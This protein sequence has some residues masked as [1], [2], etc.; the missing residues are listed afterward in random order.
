MPNSSENYNLKL[1]LQNEYY[2]VD[3]FNSNFRII[4]TELKKLEENKEPKIN[5]KSGFNLDKT[6]VPENNTNKL[7]SAKGA[8]DLK[9]WLVSA[10][11]NAINTTK[12]AL[13][14]LIK[15]KLPHG[16]YGGT[17]QDLKNLVD[18]KEPKIKRSSSVTSTSE[19]DVATSKAVKSA[20]DNANIRL[21]NGY[22]STDFGGNANNI[23][24]AQ[25]L[26]LIKSKGAFQQSYW[27]GRGS[28]YYAGN[29]K[30]NDTGCGDIHLAGAVVEVFGT[31]GSHTIRITTPTTSVGGIVNAEFIYVNNGGDYSPGWRKNY[32]N[33][34]KP[35]PSEIGTYTKQEID[36]RLNGKLNNNYC[37]YAVGQ[38]LQTKNIANPATLYPGTTWKK[39]EGRFL[40]ATSG[41]EAA[42]GTGG[43]SSIKILEA[44]LPPHGHKFSA[45]T[46][47]TG[48]H[49]HQNEKHRHKVDNHSHTQP[50]HT[51]AVSLASQGGVFQKLS[52]EKTYLKGPSH[53]ENAGTVNFGNVTAAGGETTGGSAPYTDYQNPNTST[54][55]NHNHTV[56]GTTSTT[57]SGA[58]INIM[59]LYHKVHIWERT[60]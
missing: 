58:A 59:P 8:L 53:R 54:D 52:S 11:T 33:K 17:G 51:H 41:S 28:W 13:E 31:E 20:N 60:A 12:S 25:F 29:Q 42:G 21:K 37:P 6:D 39:I 3:D 47:T 35:T 32:N 44:N 22:Q 56:S 19:T 16:G 48:N 40:L 24:T 7:F 4:D 14:N 18:S 2:D 23:T 9:N 49:Y 45:T 10:Y 34:N 43:V 27:I 50:A 38:L 30:I 5:K 36:S 26:Q 55:G 46:N 57:G 1:P 15:T